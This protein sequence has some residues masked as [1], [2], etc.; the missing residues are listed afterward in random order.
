MK[1]VILNTLNTPDMNFEN[2]ET[3]D[4][5]DRGGLVIIKVPGTSYVVPLREITWLEVHDE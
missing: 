3:V 5:D 2:V 1:T 4:I